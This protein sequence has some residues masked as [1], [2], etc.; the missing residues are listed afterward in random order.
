MFTI[1]Y[2]THE[3][4]TNNISMIDKGYA[5]F[6]V[7]ALLQAIDLEHLDLIDGFT[8]EVLFSWDNGKIDWL[9]I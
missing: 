6:T 2:R 8:G 5:L 9:A 3:G 7:N 4:K 1:T